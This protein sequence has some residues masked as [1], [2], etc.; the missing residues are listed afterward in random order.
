ML[1]SIG[2][3]GDRPWS[4]QQQESNASHCLALVTPLGDAENMQPNTVRRI[5]ALPSTKTTIASAPS[6]DDPSA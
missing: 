1:G 6:D 2:S 3:G 4:R 5:D